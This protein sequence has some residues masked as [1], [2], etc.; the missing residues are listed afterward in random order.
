MA[1][2]GPL[3]FEGIT[4]AQFAVLGEKARA[5]GIALEGNSGTAEKFGV[6]VRWDYAPDS[7][8]L[9]FEVLKTPF[10]VSEDDVITRLRKMVEQSLA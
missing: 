7:G 5:A 3:T 8:R 4:P 10:F 1:E 6:A 9:A 2:S